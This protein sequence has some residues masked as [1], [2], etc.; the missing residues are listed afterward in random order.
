MVT[1]DEV[2]ALRRFADGR[3]IGYP[4]LADPKSANIRAFGLLNERYP[5]GSYAHGVAHPLTLVVDAGGVVRHR[6]S[7]RDYQDRP[8]PEVVLSA[9]R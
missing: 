1:Y 9:I 8:P 6:F 7:L 4:L 3:D 2:A 5:P